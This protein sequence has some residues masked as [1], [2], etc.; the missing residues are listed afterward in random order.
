M[1]TEVKHLHA[2]LGTTSVFVTHDQ[3][4]AMALSDRVAVIRDGKVVQYGTPHEVYQRPQDVYVASFIG[5]PRVSLIEGSLEAHDDRVDFV[6]DG[7]QVN[8]GSQHR[9][10]S[11]RRSGSSVLL[12]VR[13]ED[14][15]V[16]V[17]PPDG[18]ASSLTATI[19]LV[20]PV[21]ADTFLELQV[22]A[23]TLVAR[24]APDPHYAVGDTVFVTLAATRLHL[25]D[26]ATGSRIN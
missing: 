19:Q 12:G 18:D 16:E 9:L 24:A 14:A 15:R 2:E 26:R 23:S 10:V 25:F 6:T 4:E 20:E 7:L 8:L 5:R 1:R 17:T 13:A 3:E 11:A 22:G 21:G